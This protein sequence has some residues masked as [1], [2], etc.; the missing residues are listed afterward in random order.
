MKT[1]EEISDG[2]FNFTIEKRSYINEKMM[3]HDLWS[4]EN[5][6]AWSSEEDRE[7]AR[8]NC[9]VYTIVFTYKSHMH[10]GM[11]YGSSMEA[12]QKQM[13][14][15]DYVAIAEDLDNLYVKK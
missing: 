10:G 9:F 14:T 7:L 5:L 4:F 15:L 12:L 2:L 6:K 1:W 13:S 3:I 8:S 11:S